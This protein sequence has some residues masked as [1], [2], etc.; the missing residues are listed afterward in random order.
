MSYRAPPPVSTMLRMSPGSSL[1]YE[2]QLCTILSSP[3]RPEA[4]DARTASQVGWSRY[5]N[6]SI[7][8]TPSASQASIIRSAS[9]VVVARGFSHRTCLPARA[10][11]IVHSA[12]RWLG[13]GL[14]TASTSGSASRS[15]YEPYARAMPSSDAAAWA[16]PRSRE[17]IATTSHRA[18][19]AVAG[20]TFPIPILAV[21]RTP[22][23]STSTL[24][25]TSP[26]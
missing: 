20:M 22:H 4:T 16:R 18:A 24:T 2:N 13:S 19:A 10:A 1:K 3:M 14:Y 21:E 9:A 11:A 5:M 8:R 26:P 17:A 15:S 7:S 23:R 25:P 6:A 12:C